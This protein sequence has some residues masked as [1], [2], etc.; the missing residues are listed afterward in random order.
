LDIAAD[1]WSAFPAERQRL[2]KFLAENEI[3][4][5]HILTG[6]LH[7]GHAVSAQL[8][9][10]GGRRLP[11]VEFCASPFEQRSVWLSFGYIPVFSRWLTR[12]KRHFYRAYPNF[13]IIQVNFDSPKPSV[14]FTLHYRAGEWKTS[15]ITV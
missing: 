8:K 9:C 1:R 2:L 15:S 10:P 4:G 6:D 11:I 5:V 14:T 12:A 7:S 13:G 3:E